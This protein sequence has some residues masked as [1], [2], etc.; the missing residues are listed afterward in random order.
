MTNSLY[1]SKKLEPSILL[2]HTKLPDFNMELTRALCVDIVTE[3]VRECARLKVSV[4][5]THDQPVSSRRR[6][7]NTDPSLFLWSGELDWLWE[8]DSG[9]THAYDVCND[10]A[11]NG[12]DS[13]E[14]I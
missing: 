12:F 2:A 3:T 5:T 6:I 10:P 7:Q 14:E 9:L 4:I 11:Q 1:C 13:A 8:A